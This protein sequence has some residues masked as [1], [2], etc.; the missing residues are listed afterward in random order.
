MVADPIRQNAMDSPKYRGVLHKWC[1]F[2]SMP[3][4]IALVISAPSGRA[5]F[6]A[7]IFAYCMAAMFGISALFHLTSFNDH[8]WYRFRRLDHMGIYLAIAGGYTPFGMLAL[9]G[10][11]SYVMLIGG[12]AGASL[13]IVLRFMPFTPPFGMMNALFISLGWVAIVTSGQLWDNVGHGWIILTIL[14]GGFYTVGAFIVGARWPDPWPN[15]FGY[16]EIW[17]VMVAIAA[18]LH[19]IVVAFAI[20]PMGA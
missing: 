17:H 7:A 3:I 16:H 6:A 4:G 12:R 5:A 2:A 13:G 8:G 18:A 14:G 15:V 10:W 11:A 1:F 19:Y 9:D 20:I